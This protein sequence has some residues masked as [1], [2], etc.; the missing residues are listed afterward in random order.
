MDKKEKDAIN[1]YT[2]SFQ[3]KRVYNVCC[4]APRCL[5]QVHRRS[6]MRRSKA[7]TCHNPTRGMKSREQQC[8]E[9]G[10]KYNHG[11]TRKMCSTTC[12]NN[13]CS[14]VNEIRRRARLLRQN[15]GRVMGGRI[16]DCAT[17]LDAELLAIYAYLHRVEQRSEDPTQ[18]TVLVMSDCLNAL[19]DRNRRHVARK[20]TLI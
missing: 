20:R 11:R 9:Y 7:T 15:A 19:K 6:S 18:R 13:A 12:F 5:A 16:G 1:K 10:R 3:N 17:V 8:I 2:G 14:N 4:D